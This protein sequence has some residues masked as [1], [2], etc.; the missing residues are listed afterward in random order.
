MK[1]RKLSYEISTMY[2][3]WEST[4]CES[5][6]EEKTAKSNKRIRGGLA[7]NLELRPQNWTS[8]QSANQTLKY[9]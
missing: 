9:T 8:N 2:E 7:S 1:P 5:E 3:E 6:T 4:L